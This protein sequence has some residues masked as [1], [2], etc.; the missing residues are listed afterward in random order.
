MAKRGTARSDNP[1]L[2]KLSAFSAF[3][4]AGEAAIAALGSRR[5]THVARGQDII[6]EGDDPRQVF[7]I[8]EGWA[9]RYKILDDGRRQILAFF[10]P[11]DLCD[12]HVYILKEMDHSIAAM[13][14]VR[15]ATISSAELETIGDGHPPVLRALWWETLVADSIQ[16]AWT[17]NVGQREALEALA[18]LCCEIFVRLRLVGLAP[19]GHC[20]WPLTQIDLADAL[21]ITPTH[22]SRTIRKLNATGMVTIKRGSLMIHDAAGLMRLAA[23][24]PNYLHLQGDG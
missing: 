10:L 8:L 3:S 21:G 9:C 20:K 23:F 4:E 17:V 24:N 14:A 16:R 18:H 1:L 12:L 22:V 6:R 19:Q 7:L 15:M 2:R 5:T 11:G 13:S